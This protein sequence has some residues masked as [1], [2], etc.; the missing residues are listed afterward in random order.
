MWD[1]NLQLFYNQSTSIRWTKS[2]IECY[3]RQMKCKGCFYHET[4]FK[5]GNYKKCQ[6]K[7]TVMELYRRFGKPTEEEQE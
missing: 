6:M 2:A 3:E 5:H 1:N 7:A 4:Y